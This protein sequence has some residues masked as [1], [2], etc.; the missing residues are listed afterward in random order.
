MVF[1]WTVVLHNS[2]YPLPWLLTLGIVKCSDPG[3]YLISLTGCL[4]DSINGGDIYTKAHSPPICPRYQGVKA[5]SLLL[6]SQ[7]TVDR[8]LF[9]SDSQFAHWIKKT[10]RGPSISKSLIFWDSLWLVWAKPIFKVK[11]ES[12]RALERRGK[13]ERRTVAAELRSLRTGKGSDCGFH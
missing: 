12:L 10:S 1:T 6:T 11:W 9:L 4:Y 5:L 7:V 8:S 3:C 2:V 13:L